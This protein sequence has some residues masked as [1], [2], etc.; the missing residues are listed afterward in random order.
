MSNEQ[1]VSQA[2]ASG[3]ERA[4]F[5]NDR[6]AVTPTVSVI[7]PAYNAADCVGRAIES[8]LAQTYPPLEILVVDDG[9]KDNTAEVVARYPAPV[10]LIRQANGGTGAA[11]NRAAREARGSWLAW[12][13]A[14]D[15]WEPT[16]LERQVQYTADPM[17]GIIH[18]LAVGNNN[19]DSIPTKITFQQL[20]QKNCIGV[21]SVIIRR[22]AFEQV[23]GFNPERGLMSVADYNLWLRTTWAGWQVATCP[24]KLWSYTPA[25]GSLS[26][27]TE[28]M[29]REEL[30]NVDV[31]AQE[32][33]LPAGLVAEKRFRICKEYGCELFYYRELASA[34]HYISLA[35]R[36]RLS[37]LL[38]LLWL[39]TYMPPAALNLRRKAVS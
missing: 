9:S 29:T 3:P 8:A 36:A 7:I 26:S 5:E 16:K 15:S 38:M 37:P 10:R 18:C 14:D 11:R 27:Q 33:K 25:T 1:F 28:R 31:I 4:G 23:G 39:L 6:S 24:E 22:S 30:A 20:W 19:A 17:V 2:T 21:S 34:R 12:L 32:L 35:L 13:D